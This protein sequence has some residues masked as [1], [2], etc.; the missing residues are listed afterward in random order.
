MIVEM[1]FLRKSSL[2]SL[3]PWNLSAV[4]RKIEADRHT[5]LTRKKNRV[6]AWNPWSSPYDF[7]LS[8]IRPASRGNTDKARF[9]SISIMPKPEPSRCGGTTMGTVGTIIVQKIA[10]QTPKKKTGSHGTIEESLMGTLVSV[11]NMKV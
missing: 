6:W 10:T 4:V 9:C 7:W 2:Q 1:Y 5:Q 11:Y 8:R 3:L